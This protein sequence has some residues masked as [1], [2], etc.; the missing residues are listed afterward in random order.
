MDIKFKCLAGDEKRDEVDQGGGDTCP[1][2][3]PLDASNGDNRA[4]AFD[5]HI[6]SEKCVQVL[7]VT[8]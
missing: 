1:L 4:D 3:L 6:E 5:S 8:Y 2:D 7:R